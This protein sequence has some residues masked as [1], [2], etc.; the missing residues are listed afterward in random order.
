MMA[1]ANFTIH[2][3]VT[4]YDTSKKRGRYKP[5]PLGALFNLIRQR[6]PFESTPGAHPSGRL[7]HRKII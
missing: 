7:S 4:F 5:A 6:G 3:Y 1:L 2:I